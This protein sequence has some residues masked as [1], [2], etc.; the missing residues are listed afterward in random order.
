MTK[1]FKLNYPA[2][3]AEKIIN[4]IHTGELHH[5]DKSEEYLAWLAE[6]N[7]ALPADGPQQPENP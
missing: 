3:Y 5:I 7:E 2:P 1:N 6:G 4:E